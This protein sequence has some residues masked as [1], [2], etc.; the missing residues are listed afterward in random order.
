MYLKIVDYSANKDVP[1]IIFWEC[2]T[3]AMHHYNG[4]DVEGAEEV[5]V[6]IT[7]RSSNPDCNAC[8]LAYVV[9]SKVDLFLMNNSG[10]TIDR[11][12]I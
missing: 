3:V 5:R 9:G 11:K 6:T 4:P 8:E 10:K 2:E 7:Q 12:N 1:D